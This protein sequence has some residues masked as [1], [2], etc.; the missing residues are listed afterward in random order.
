[1]CYLHNVIYAQNGILLI[2]EIETSL[3]YKY[4]EEILTFLF[5]VAD[6]FNVQIF[7]STHSSETINAILK[8]ANTRNFIS[9]T[10]I[11]TLRQNEERTLCRE[12]SGTEALNS[13]VDFGFEVRD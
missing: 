11:Y 8:V 6:K 5:R 7:I 9:T 2:D 10:K 1:M 12:L 4:F 3:H 13:I